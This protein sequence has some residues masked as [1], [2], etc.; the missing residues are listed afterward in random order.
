MK[1]TYLPETT[2]PTGSTVFPISTA[3]VSKK[4]QLSTLNSFSGT[5][6]IGNVYA[7]QN[8]KLSPSPASTVASVGFT[9][10]GAIFPFPSDNV[11][12][13]W[14]L[15]N[16]SAVSRQTYSALFSVI[17]LTY[18][19]GDN[20]TTFNLPDLRGRTIVGLETM[21]GVSSSGRLSNSRPGNFNGG[22]LGA[23]GGSESHLVSLSEGA[24]LD[25]THSV[26]SSLWIYGSRED[27]DGRGALYGDG[28]N[29]FD[30]SYYTR[31]I[32]YSLTIGSNSVSATQTHSNLP[33]LVFLNY[34]VKY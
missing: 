34:I 10:P 29:T 32:N 1:I 3:G 25:H 8:I 23:T 2:S 15:C 13:G 26:T 4:V 27:G 17:G 22:I 6:T 33:P 5:G 11:P 18:G 9:F 28:D 14:L 16:G 24:V 12:T 19:S 31:A 20:R 7:G 21:G 30:D